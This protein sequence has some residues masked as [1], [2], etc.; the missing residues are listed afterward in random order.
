MNKK[1]LFTLIP[2]LLVAGLVGA[3]GVI[4][5]APGMS[6]NNTQIGSSNTT[7][8]LNKIQQ[9]LEKKNV[10]ID[11]Q[12]FTLKELGFHYDDKELEKVISEHK[13]WNLSTW[14]NSITIPVKLDEDKAEKT[15]SKNVKSYVKPVNAQV[16]EKGNKFTVKKGSNGN[17]VDMKK[18]IDAVNESFD[19][20]EDSTTIQLE[21]VKPELT[22]K[23]AKKFVK[24]INKQISQGTIYNDKHKIT[25]ISQSKFSDFV[26][27][28]ENN[29][30]LEVATVDEKIDK[31]VES[32]PQQVN[33]K[34]K[35]GS[36]V[37]DT[38]GNALKVLKAYN[39][40]F[41]IENLDGLKKNIKD[42]I[43]AGESKFNTD[44]KYT[45]AKVDERL[46]KGVIDLSE[47][48]AYMYENGKKVASYPVAIGKPAT[49]TD[50][51]EFKVFIQYKSKDMGCRAGYDYCSRGVPY[52]TFYNGGEAFHGAPW[53]NDFGNPGASQRS[54]GCV[55]MRVGDAKKVYEFLQVGSPVTV[56]Q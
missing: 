24:K 12:K 27:V 26:K 32:L 42:G 38:E 17:K 41:T 7:Q 47:R 19:K 39:D 33:R 56:K 52:A 11:G 43:I 50:I 22:T 31:F 1:V 21:T 20:K 35:N 15:L 51:G 30:E 25:N 8:A 14:N 10:E 40:G 28:S 16:K 54:H 9:E 23:N 46:R 2:L 18:M 44:G 3:L 4:L 6:V 55:N 45:P 29:G 34:A 36:A 48:R 5:V 37:V 13:A 49:P 53:H